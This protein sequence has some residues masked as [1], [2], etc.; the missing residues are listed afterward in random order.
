[1]QYELCRHVK[2]NGRQCQAAALAG[3]IW[4]YSTTHYTIYE[5]A[6]ITWNQDFAER[7]L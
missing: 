5:N 6:L 1:M 7:S 2:T 4:C 3:G